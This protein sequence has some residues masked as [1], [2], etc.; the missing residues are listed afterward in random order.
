[1]IPKW[2]R[3]PRQLRLVFLATMML[4]AGT[5]GWLGWRL[6]QQDQQLSAQRMAERRETA[7]DLAVAAL[8]RRLAAIDQDVTRL[9]A[10]GEPHQAAGDGALF[11]EFRPG[12]IRVWPQG[13]LL[14]LPDLPPS[15]EPSAAL[16]TTSDQ[17]EFQKHDYL[18]AIA[19][20][21]QPAASSDPGVR[22][23]ALARIARNYRKAAQFRESQQYYRQ[24]ASLGAVPVAGM[25]A[26]LAGALGEMAVFERQ[27]D[28][29]SLGTTAAG[30]VR[31][32]H[33]GRWPITSATYRY[34]MQEAAH[35]APESDRE[36]AQAMALTEAVER[37]WEQWRADHALLVGRSGLETS[38]GPVLAVWRGSG[39]TLAA[40]IA[41]PDFLDKQW[42]ASKPPGLALTSPDGRHVLGSRPAPGRRSAIRLASATQLPWN[43]QVFEAKDADSA[44]FR[45]RRA[46]LIAA[47]TTLLVM[48]VTGGWFIGHTVARELAVARLQ[49]DFVSAVSH[50]FRTP[51]TTL[52]QLS[53]LLKR[54]RVAGE[55]DK[56]AY[57]D[58]LY[59]ES[60]RLWRLVEG[61]LN[62]GRLEAGRMRF[63][64]ESVDTGE[65]VRQS[66][67]EFA[68]AQQ[69]TGHHFD[70]ETAATAPLVQAD[71]EALRC[72]LWNLFE[73]AAKYSPDCDTVRVMV[74]G[75]AR[76]VEIAVR[77]RGVGIPR[78]EQRRIFEKFVRGS[79]AR[80]SNIRGTGIGLAMARQIVRAH[81][82]DI[83][84]ESE[85]GQGS[86]FRVLLPVK[87]T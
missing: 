41:G 37:L 30:L 80:E 46:L 5:L 59:G 69:S 50:E 79:A 60:H 67:A 11:L 42:T 7:A 43:V 15:P 81:G 22:A 16:F 87:G 1:M 29:A 78:H 2:L 63:R 74:A 47:M 24:V 25:P 12:T 4:L 36:P 13:R 3:G 52:C 35:W 61:L 32:L 23:A 76:G 6:L 14:Y 18:G 73:N 86:T 27:N 64:L 49:S 8:D 56:Q 38:A 62:F 51:L 65:L 54:G 84:V 45:S 82:G 71:R 66:A 21:R 70:V 58:L 57:Y 85:P 31:Q 17:L 55:Q 10:T 26:T 19:A 77:D 53:E 83:T 9:L 34:V 44:A 72:V 75:N 40:F 68:Q 28:R 39:S 48:I 20:L 33:S